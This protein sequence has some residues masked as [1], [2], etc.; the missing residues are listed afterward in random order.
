MKRLGWFGLL[1]FAV[2]I[3][4]M[5]CAETTESSVD[6]DVPIYQPDGDQEDGDIDSPDGDVEEELAEFD[7]EDKPEDGDEPIDGDEP[8]VFNPDEPGISM[9]VF[10]GYIE[11]MGQG[12][13]MAVGTVTPATREEFDGAES[14]IPDGPM[15]DNCTFSSGEGEEPVDECQTD[16]D[17]APEQKCLA[18]QD[19]GQKL[20]RTPIDA[21]DVGPMMISGFEGGERTFASNPS[22]SGAYTENG[23]GDGSME[24]GSIAFDTTYTVTGEG[25][26]AQGLG[27]FSG[28]IL[29]PARITL[30]SPVPEQTSMGT[31]AIPI[32]INQD[33]PIAWE[34]SG[35]PSNTFTVSISGSTGTVTCVLSDD[36]E[37]VIPK[38]LIAHAGLNPDP[39]WSI[40]NM[41]LI[42]SDAYSDI[43]GDGITRSEMTFQQI[44]MLN[45]TVVQ[46]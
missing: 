14:D 43:S 26:A 34:G 5:A 12:Q 10:I 24:A 45:A 38:D 8:D 28:S 16:A 19:S 21:L 39:M 18:D 27:A 11:M 44:I 31:S 13:E 37:Y 40:M 6:G 15:I 20:C 32:D 29:A 9:T 1:I 23:Q 22:Q 17:C 36:G 3:G 25:D 46:P 4:A 2:G 41:V 30:T 35:D 7:I 42:Q 33:L